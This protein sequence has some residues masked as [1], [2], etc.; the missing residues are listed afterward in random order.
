MKTFGRNSV[1]SNGDTLG[2]KPGIQTSKIVKAKAA[3]FLGV[4]AAHGWR[5][6]VSERA[7]GGPLALSAPCSAWQP[8]GNSC[9]G[10]RRRPF[11]R[12]RAFQDSRKF[13]GVPG[14]GGKNFRGKIL[15]RPRSN[16]EAAAGPNAKPAEASLAEPRTAEAER[17]FH[18]AGIPSR[19]L[20]C[21]NHGIHYSKSGSHFPQR[22]DARRTEHRFPN[23]E[24]YTPESETA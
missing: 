10:A 17:Q 11:N 16:R 5:V 13:S 6:S 20:Q 21:T 19:E 8:E 23:S 22:R 24:F 18:G 7:A 15:A 9:R 2:K 14:A 12:G 1:P 4:P 3:Q